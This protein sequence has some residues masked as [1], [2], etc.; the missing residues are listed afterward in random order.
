MQRSGGGPDGLDLDR[1]SAARVYDY[2]LGGAHNFAVDRAMAEQAIALW[3]E[4]PATIRANRAFLRR[5]VRFLV[6]QGVRQFLDLGSGIPTVGNV[7]EIAQAAAP[8]ARVVYVDIDP[9]AV[10][11]SQLM[12]AG[13]E[14]ATAIHADLRRPAQVLADPQLRALL[15]LDQPVAVLM[16]AVLHF[17]P[18]SDDPAGIVAAYRDTVA[19]GSY[20]ALSHATP[21]GQEERAE[22]HQALYARTATPM[23]MRSRDEVAALLGGWEVLPPG[24]VRLPAWRP[25]PG[26]DVSR[27]G[28]ATFAG[29]AAVARRP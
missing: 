11:D 4:L 18:D 29:R 23:T 5:A 16:V 17:V 13:N 8:D 3:P 19:P 10:T 6:D 21:D 22:T 27:A 12:L 9:V 2:Y 24:V 26:D 1:P 28:A 15:D 14:R 20:L 25:E 7:H